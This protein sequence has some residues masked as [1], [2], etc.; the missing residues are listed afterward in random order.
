[1]VTEAT[2]GSDDRIQQMALAIEKLTKSLEEK[3]AQVAALMHRLEL[4][5]LAKEDQENPGSSKLKIWRSKNINKNKIY[6]IAQSFKTFCATLL[7]SPL[8]HCLSISFN[9]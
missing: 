3:D 8:A 9:I 5:N 1:M 7:N 2:S 4:Q 6:M